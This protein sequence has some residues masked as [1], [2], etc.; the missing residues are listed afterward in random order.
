MKKESLHNGPWDDV[1]WLHS[2][3]SFLERARGVLVGNKELSKFDIS[4][5]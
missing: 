1:M 2:D 5:L 3:F 4:G